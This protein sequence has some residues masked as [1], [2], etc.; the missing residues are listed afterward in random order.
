MLK[1]SLRGLIIGVGDCL[2]DG[3]IGLGRL[4]H[5]LWTFVSPA[6]APYRRTLALKRSLCSS[7]R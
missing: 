3:P 5:R 2:E 7:N 1:H 6:A 4:D